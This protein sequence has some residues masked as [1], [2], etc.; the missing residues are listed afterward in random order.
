MISLD[1]FMTHA[2]LD[3]VPGEA[4]YRAALLTAAEETV[5]G[6]TGK[7]RP[8]DDAAGADVYDVAVMMLAAH[9]YD[10]R[11]PVDT[12]TPREIP[13]TMQFLLNHIALCG[14]YPKG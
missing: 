7:A 8:P 5:R 6:V 14:I 2:H 9:W 11:T 12:G 4:A 13:Y 3:D 10:I 1:R